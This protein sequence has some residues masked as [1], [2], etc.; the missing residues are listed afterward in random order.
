[1]WRH[2]NISTDLQ[3]GAT[4]HSSVMAHLLPKLKEAWWRHLRPFDLEVILLVPRAMDNLNTTFEL[5]T[6]YH[7]RFTSREGQ[8]R[9]QDF[10]VGGGTPVTW[11]EGPMRGWIFWGGA[12]QRGPPHQ[13][14]GLGRAVIPHPLPSPKSP[15][16][17]TNPVAMPVDGR[18]G[19]GACP[20]CPPVATLLVKAQ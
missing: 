6:S 19:R 12:A 1:M 8:E 14:G 13:L 18:G 20:L 3:H 15:G 4:L 2:Y 10:Q 5:S 9:S 11:P 16:I 17:C 7:S